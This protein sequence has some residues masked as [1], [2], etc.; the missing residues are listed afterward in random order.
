MSLLAALRIDYPV[1][2][3]GDQDRLT[4]DGGMKAG[5]GGVQN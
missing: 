5:T 3:Q 4:H 1:I 2:W